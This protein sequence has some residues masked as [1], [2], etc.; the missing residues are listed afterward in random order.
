MTPTQYQILGILSEHATVT[1]LEIAGLLQVA[2]PTATRAVDAL[3]QKGLLVKD[4]D[5]QD[6]RIVW[7]RLTMKGQGFYVDERAMRLARFQQW[8]ARLTADEQEVLRKLL[9]KLAEEDQQA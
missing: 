8:A 3:E 9:D 5:P 6:R 2:A 1:L 4:R 7:L